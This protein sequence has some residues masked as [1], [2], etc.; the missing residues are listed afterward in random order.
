MMDWLKKRAKRA[1]E[2]KRAIAQRDAL[3]D[4]LDIAIRQVDRVQQSI[5]D[6]YRAADEAADK[7]Q[8]GAAGVH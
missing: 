7:P 1:P 8:R 2:V 5:L 6:D 3:F 4:D